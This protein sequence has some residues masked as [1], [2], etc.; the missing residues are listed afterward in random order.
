MSPPNDVLVVLLQLYPH[1]LPT[2]ILVILLQPYPHFLPN[3]VLIVLV[4][5]HVCTWAAS[6]CSKKSMVGSFKQ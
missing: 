6:D 3:D 4:I 2:D 1:S 5:V